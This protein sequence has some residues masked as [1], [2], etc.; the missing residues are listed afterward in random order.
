MNAAIF[1]GGFYLSNSGV[2]HDLQTGFTLAEKLL[3][4]GKVLETLNHLCKI[5]TNLAK[6]N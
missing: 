3:T 5:G 2:C 6:L 4:Q 1:N